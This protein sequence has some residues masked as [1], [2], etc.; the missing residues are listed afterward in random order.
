[1]NKKENRNVNSFDLFSPLLEAF[2]ELFKIGFEVVTKLILSLLTKKIFN[3]K[4]TNTYIRLNSEMLYE[5]KQTDDPEDLGW[6]INYG[7]PYKLKYF[8]P[9]LHTFIIGA[10]GW[11]KTNLLNILQE[12]SLKKKRPMI[13]IDPK[14]GISSIND[15]KRKCKA[16][17]QKYY[18]FSEH[19]GESNRFNPIANLNQSQIV[20]MIMRSFDWGDRPNVYYLKCA[21]DALN[22]SVKFLKGKGTTFGLWDVYDELKEK[23]NTDDAKGLIVQLQL[24]LDSDFGHLFKKAPNSEMVTLRSAWEEG[25]CI[26]IGVPTQGYSS[27]AKTIGKFFISELQSLSNYIEATSENQ[28]A[29]LK[30]SMS[31]FL[32]EAGSLLYPDFLDLANK[33]RSSGINLT[34]AMQSYS[35]M[36]AIAGSEILMKQLM[37]CISNVFVQKQ[38]NSDNAE[39]LAS[40]LGTYLSEKKTVM[41]EAGSDSSRG[42]TREAYEYLCHPDIIKS[43]NIGQAILLTHNPKDIHLLNIR[44]AKMGMVE[45]KKKEERKLPIAKPIVEKS[46]SKKF[47]GKNAQ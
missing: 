40:A 21:E 33:C 15:F 16:H 18:I 10:S 44:N 36:E 47:G 20:Q 24:I 28:E 22:Q 23:H 11:G 39:K 29:S 4:N 12:N 42:S 41:T 6:S 7:L 13:F 35:D 26:Y 27:L 19:Y 25:S 9:E 38:T 45:L 46:F 37:D 1:M 17:G 8:H 2:A 31:V 3:R 43:I 5:R 34:L 14:G 32:D 30:K